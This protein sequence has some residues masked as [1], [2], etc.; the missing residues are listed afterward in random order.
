[1]KIAIYS[2]YLDTFGGGEKYMMTIAEVFCIDNAVDVL[3]DKHLLSFGAEYL[4]KELSNR[5]NL[6]LNIADFIK[7]P[8]GKDSNVFERLFFLSHYD[9]L[10]YLTDGSIFLPNAKNNILHI[11]S[12]LAGESSKGLWGKIKLK[13]WNLIIYNSEFTKKNS[14]QNWPITS[15]VIYPPVDIARIKPLKKKKY[16]LSVGRFFGYLK[17]KKHSVL[18]KVFKDLYNDG[19][20]DN[21]SLHLVGSAATGDKDYLNELRNLAKNIPVFF[22][23]NLNYDL[24]IKLYGESSIYW[25]ATGFNETE[26][27]KMEH[28][29][30]ATVEA[31]AAGCVPVVINKG[32]QKEIVENNKNGYLWNS[33][34]ELKKYTTFL[35]KEQN[36]ISQLSKYALLAG[37]KFSKKKFEEEIFKLIQK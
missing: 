24:L 28:F 31:M 9:L 27:T 19:L 32:G 8:I 16:I 5:F 14:E 25:H 36:V 30:I 2:P 26:P 35:T 15:K 22:Y 37:Q 1:M 18:I 6:N 33:L 11:Q 12:P 17:D 29:G 23:P 4:K 10:F 13:G 7:G 3:L 20:V 21:W 34:E